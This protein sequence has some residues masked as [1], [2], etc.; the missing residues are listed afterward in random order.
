MID[1]TICESALFHQIKLGDFGVHI[2][3]YQFDDH[4]VKRPLCRQPLVSQSNT[5]SSI[6][7]SAIAQISGATAP[8]LW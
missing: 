2:S 3:S 6:F 1:R 5:V 8:L 4:S 7:F